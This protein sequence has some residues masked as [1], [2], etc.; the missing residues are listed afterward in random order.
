MK[1]WELL[2]SLD[3]D[4]PVVLLDGL[5]GAVVGVVDGCRLVYDRTRC[6]ALLVDQGM[7]W[8]EAVEWYEFNT[9]RTVQHLG[10]RG[11]L[12]MDPLPVR[13][14]GEDEFMRRSRAQQSIPRFPPPEDT[15]E[16]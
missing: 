6:L 3:P 7:G 8:D 2:E 16:W 9:V 4:E 11:P 15:G 5:D 12:L 1:R 14:T 13:D 10:D